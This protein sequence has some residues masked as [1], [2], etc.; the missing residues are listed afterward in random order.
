MIYAYL[1][2]LTTSMLNELIK[3]VVV[4]EA[5]KSTGDGSKT[6]CVCAGWGKHSGPQRR[7]GKFLL[8]LVDLVALLCY[9][10]HGYNL[11]NWCVWFSNGR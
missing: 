8:L 5:D 7:P 2:E 6:V 3:K 11:I 10:Q 1:D 4:H 9:T